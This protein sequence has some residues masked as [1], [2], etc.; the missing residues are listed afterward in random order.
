MLKLGQRFYDEKN[1]RYLTIDGVGCDPKVYRC[2]MEEYEPD[3]WDDG[4]EMVLVV[5]DTVLMREGELIK[6]QEVA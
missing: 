5:T 6:M 4:A 3:R 1:G 2:I